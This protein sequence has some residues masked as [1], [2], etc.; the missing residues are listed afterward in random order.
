M[1]RAAAHCAT[2][3]CILRVGAGR[4]RLALAASLS[5]THRT[6]L[7]FPQRTSQVTKCLDTLLDPRRVGLEI[8][9]RSKTRRCPTRRGDEPDHISTAA[10]TRRTAPA[11]ERDDILGPYAH[12]PYHSR[13]LTAVSGVC[14]ITRRSGTQFSASARRD[15]HPQPPVSTIPRAA[16]ACV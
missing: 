14:A 1:C 3:L 9:A 8:T 7:A 10:P 6:S 13:A 12:R 4:C 2:P 11:L 5:F 15:G 16:S